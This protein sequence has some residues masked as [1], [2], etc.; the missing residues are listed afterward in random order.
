MAALFI[1][2]VSRDE[3]WRLRKRSDDK[4]LTHLE[5]VR[6][7]QLVARW[8]AAKIETVVQFGKAICGAALQRNI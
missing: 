7:A 2:D 1:L 5:R 4:T 3:L 8:H 6:S